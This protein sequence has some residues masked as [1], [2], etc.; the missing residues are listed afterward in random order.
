M[1]H[2]RWGQGGQSLV[3]CSVAVVIVGLTMA[4]AIPEL[5][6][7]GT[8]YRQQAV[9]AEVASELRTARLL[10]MT[11]HQRMD[12]TFGEQGDQLEVASGDPTA[13]VVRRY[14]FRGRGVVVEGEP[15]DRSVW[16]HPTGRVAS[17]IRLLLKGANRRQWTVTV[18]LTGRVTVS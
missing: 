15:E 13:R 12:V 6:S 2:G 16:F 8:R 5:A 9:I 17:P 7:A 18:S 3:E 11:R 14:D 1:K 10:A 4:L